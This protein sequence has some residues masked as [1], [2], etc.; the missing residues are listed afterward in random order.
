MLSYDS[1]FSTISNHA[2]LL[3][4]SSVRLA[5]SLGLVLS[6]DSIATMPMP[7]FTNS[8]MDGFALAH[9]DTRT[10]SPACPF[11]L[12]IVYEV[13]AGFAPL[14]LVPGT[15]MRIMT[16]APLPE[17]ADCVVPVEDTQVTNGHIAIQERL[18]SG[19]NVR[20]AGSDSQPGDLLCRS[21]SVITPARMAIHAMFGFTHVNIV[22][23]PKVAIVTTGDELVETGSVLQPGQIYNSNR[24]GLIGLLQAIGIEPAVVVHAF[25]HEDSAAQAL[26]AC[27]ECDVIISSGGVSM[28]DYD[29]MRRTVEHLGKVEFWK[30]AVR[31][32]KPFVFGFV[33]QSMFFGLPGN[34]V[35]TMVTFELYVRPVL[36]KMAGHTNIWRRTVFAELTEDYNHQPGR[37]DFVRVSV[38]NLSGR[39]TATPH[40]KQ[41]SGTLSSMAD[42]DGLAVLHE[43]LTIVERGTVVPVWMIE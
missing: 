42:C 26:A 9:A 10:A 12:E 20:F 43:D 21:G 22:R 36:L 13:R 19:Q 5:D 41:G 17:G 28:G 18:T 4:C 35:S 38:S 11:Q 32:G 6:D 25:D 14:D 31:P 30:T 15:A 8:A 40:A 7:L 3:S 27:S 24:V 16:G 23:R 33:G 34:P 1:A 29:V 39:A 2:K 37:R